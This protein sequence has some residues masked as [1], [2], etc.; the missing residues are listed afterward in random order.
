MT[1]IG[2]FLFSANILADDKNLCDD[3]IRLNYPEKAILNCLESKDDGYGPS[4]YYLNSIRREAREFDNGL[5]QE[6]REEEDSKRKKIITE[7]LKKSITTK[8]FSFNDLK[9]KFF[10]PIVATKVMRKNLKEK[11]ISDPHQLCVKLKFQ[12]ATGFELIPEEGDLESV[13][14]NFIKKDSMIPFTKGHSVKAWSSDEDDDVLNIF[15]FNSITCAKSSKKKNKV[16]E[17]IVPLVTYSM[18]SLARG[19]K[20][21]RGAGDSNILSERDLHYDPLFD[22]DDYDKGQNSARSRGDYD[23][24]ISPYLFQRSGEK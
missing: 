19:L 24:D 8:K 20:A 21:P 15:Y 16:L 12:K 5:L 18:S 13:R 23:M 9:K 10:N 11:Q 7:L 14:A 17:D 22:Y 1:L 6:M 4:E 3:Y 2:S